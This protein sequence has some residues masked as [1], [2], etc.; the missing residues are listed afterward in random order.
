MAE[1]INLIP[2]SEKQEQVREKAVKLSTVLALFLMLVV[3]GVAG[4]FYYQKT[5]L[6]TQVSNTESEITSL[7]GKIKELAATEIVARNLYTKYNVL[8]GIFNERLKYSALLEE[9]RK[10]TSSEITLEN[11]TLTGDKI[12]ISGFGQNYL[13]VAKFM[14]DLTD[15]RF[16][17]VTPG[18][19]KLFTSVTLNSVTLSNSDNSADFFIEVKMDSSVLKGK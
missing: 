6:E 11:F 2:D 19:E 14:R 18:Y 15:P 4:Y 8:L 12:T 3:G 1:Y 13:S 7:R 9:F 17:G 16:P 10:R 5:Q